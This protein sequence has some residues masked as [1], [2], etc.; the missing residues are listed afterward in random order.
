MKYIFA[1]HRLRFPV[2]GGWFDLSNQINQS[3]NQSTKISPKDSA[4]PPKL[5]IKSLLS[6]KTFQACL[7]YT[8]ITLYVLIRCLWVQSRY[9]ASLRAMLANTGVSSEEGNLAGIYKSKTNTRR[10]T[11]TKCKWKKEK[12]NWMLRFPAIGVLGHEK[13]AVMGSYGLGVI[14]LLFHSWPLCWCNDCLCLV[15]PMPSD[16]ACMG[17]EFIGNGREGKRRKGKDGWRGRERN[18]ERETEWPASSEKGQKGSRLIDCT[19]GPKAFTRWS[20]FLSG[21]WP[22]SLEKWLM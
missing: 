20:C 9:V 13:D 10:P 19:V 5:K 11:W 22:Q 14:V 6:H 7:L 12:A 17:R 1:P 3:T 2:S 16:R 21:F 8:L 4:I 18:R 15:D